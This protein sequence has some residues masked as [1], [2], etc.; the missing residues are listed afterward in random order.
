ML[1]KSTESKTEFE[2]AYIHKIEK[3][4]WAAEQNLAIK[5]NNTLWKDQKFKVIYDLCK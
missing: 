5:M 3:N 1:F 4:S 2:S